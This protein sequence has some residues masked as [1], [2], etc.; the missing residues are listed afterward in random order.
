MDPITIAL[1]LANVAPSLLRFFGV[2][3]KPVAIAEQAIQIA[4]SVTGDGDAERALAALQGDPRLAQEYRLAVLKADG[5]FEAAYLA[6]RKDA[7]ARD[8]ALHQA[9]YRN[10]RADVMVGGAVGGLIACLV[11][12]VFFRHDIPGEVVGIVSTIAGIFG[13]CLRDA[14]Q[15]EFGSSRG[16]REKDQ[17]LSL[18]P[19]AKG[20]KS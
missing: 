14:F 2:G 10:T 5:D 7:R 13:A 18:I 4:R 9:G 15:F 20:P 16:S 11:V 6:D 19:S 12:L 17:L 1:G 3:E 8:V